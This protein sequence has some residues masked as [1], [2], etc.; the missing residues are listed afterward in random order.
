M[1]AC[2]LAALA[3]AALEVRLAVAADVEA[4]RQRLPPHGAKRLERAGAAVERAAR[5]YHAVEPAHRLVARPLERPGDE[6]GASEAPRKA[7]P[8]RVLASPP[9][10]LSARARDARRRLARA[11]PAL[12]PAETTTAA[13]RPALRRPRGERGVVTGHGE[14]AHVAR[15][16][17]GSGGHRPPARRQRPGA[18]WEQCSSYPAWRARAAARP[19]PGL[20]RGASAEV[21]KAAEGRPAQRRQP[22]TA[23]LG[24]SLLGRQGLSASKARPRAVTRAAEAGTLPALASPWAMPQPPR[25]AWRR[26]GPLQARHDQ[27]SGPWVLGGRCERPATSACVTPGPSH[28]AAARSEGIVGGSKAACGDGAV[29]LDRRRGVSRRTGSPLDGPVVQQRCMQGGR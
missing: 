25:S 22:C 29:S 18:R 19:Q 6:A 10:T 21:L 23:A 15:E 26:T 7:D 17:P 27:G 3:P 1:S 8:R 20:R 4:Q 2:V 11:R 12:W 28:L 24:R 5:H 13:D 14:S 16:G 9:V